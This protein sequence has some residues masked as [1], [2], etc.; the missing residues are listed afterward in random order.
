MMHVPLRS[1]R[2]PA[3][4][5]SGPISVRYREFR[6]W[7]STDRLGPILLKNSTLEQL[8]GGAVEGRM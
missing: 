1:R 6:H 5:L 3:Q 8:Y 2:L 7:Q 4:P